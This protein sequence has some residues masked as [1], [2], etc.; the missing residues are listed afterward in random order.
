MARIMTLRCRLF[1]HRG[2]RVYDRLEDGTPILGYLGCGCYVV[3]D[4]SD[5]RP[6]Q[7]TGDPRFRLTPWQQDGARRRAKKAHGERTL[8]RC[9]KVHAERVSA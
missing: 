1:G 7:P 5:P 6:V 4:T 2:D 8:T 9:P 3:R